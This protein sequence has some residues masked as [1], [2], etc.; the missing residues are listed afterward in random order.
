MVPVEALAGSTAANSATARVAAPGSAVLET[1]IAAAAMTRTT[2]VEVDS[3]V[4]TKAS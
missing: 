4:S 2:Q 3:I 1:P